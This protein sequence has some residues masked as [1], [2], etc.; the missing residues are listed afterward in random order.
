MQLRARISRPQGFQ[1]PNRKSP[2]AAMICRNQKVRKRQFGP[3]P[4][5][6]THLSDTWSEAVIK[7]PSG[8][9]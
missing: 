8:L 2:T 7:S 9:C 3:I 5:T 4:R 1:E 6:G